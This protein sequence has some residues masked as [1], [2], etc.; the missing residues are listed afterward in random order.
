MSGRVLTLPNANVAGSA[1]DVLVINYDPTFT[2]GGASG[3]TPA[4][5]EIPARPGVFAIGSIR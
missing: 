4:L 5:T 2:A 1:T 3:A